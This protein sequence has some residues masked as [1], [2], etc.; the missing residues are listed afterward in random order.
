MKRD[1][2]IFQVAQQNVIHR[3]ELW[4][5]VDNLLYVFTAV[6]TRVQDLTGNG[7]YMEVGSL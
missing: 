1:F 2:D 4:D 6:E 7:C 5:A 3:D